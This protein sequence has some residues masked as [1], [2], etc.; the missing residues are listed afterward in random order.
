MFYWFV[1]EFAIN[2]RTGIMG[3]IS[4]LML[5]CGAMG[6]SDVLLQKRDWLILI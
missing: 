1:Q 3:Q 6:F 5:D 2:V 4:I